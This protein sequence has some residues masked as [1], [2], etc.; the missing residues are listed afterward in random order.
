MQTFVPVF[1]HY[2]VTFGA[3]HLGEFFCASVVGNGKLFQLFVLFGIASGLCTRTCTHTGYAQ[4][5]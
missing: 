3:N 1:P 5:H 4:L 2:F